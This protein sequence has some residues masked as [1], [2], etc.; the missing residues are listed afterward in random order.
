[1]DRL[2]FLQ[3]KGI[4]DLS[5]LIQSHQKGYLASCRWLAHAKLLV[6]GLDRHGC[7]HNQSE[8]ALRHFVYS[9]SPKTQKNLLA[10]IVML[11]Q[12]LLSEHL[13]YLPPN[14]FNWLLPHSDVQQQGEGRARGGGW[15]MR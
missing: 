15:T 7:A 4:S 3:A 13:P 6:C 8:L 5:D 10:H 11:H 12:S 14:P 9:V 2:T 1:M